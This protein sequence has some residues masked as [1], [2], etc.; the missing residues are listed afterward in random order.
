MLLPPSSGVVRQHG[1]ILTM[2]RGATR[3]E[4]RSWIRFQ[5]SGKLRASERATWPSALLLGN[6]L[7]LHSQEELTQLPIE[8]PEL[9]I[10]Q[11]LPKDDF[12][13]VD[14]CDI[15]YALFSGTCPTKL[16]T[17]VSKDEFLDT[18]LQ[19]QLCSI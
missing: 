4:T 8:L 6:R 11:F 7:T 13:L 17:S 18:G 16:G 9:K 14:T 2:S 3:W 10:H 12:A 19:R 15:S 5:G 1:H